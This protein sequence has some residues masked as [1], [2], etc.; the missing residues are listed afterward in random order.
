MNNMTSRTGNFQLD[1]IARALG[2]SKTTV[3][4]AI[5]GKGRVSPETRDKVL[6]CIR[7]MN[8]TPDT[9]DK[10]VSGSRTCNIG[11]VIPMDDM[12][13]EAPF[14]QTCLMGISKCCALRNHDTL[15]IGTERGDASQLKRVLKEHKADGIVITRPLQDGS[16][17]QLI[18]QYNIPYVTVGQSSDTNAVT[19]D[20]EHRDGCCQL[21]SYLM[22]NN[23]PNKL[24]LIIGSMEQTVN[25]S[26]YDGFVKAVESAG[27]PVPARTV[28][29]GV[30]SELQLRRV[31]D[32]LLQS[33][34]SC[35]I[36]GDDM[37][38][39]HVIN[40]LASVGKSIP[41][42]I[43]VA[44]FYN[45]MYLDMNSPPIT[46]LRFRASDLGAAA[47]TLLLDM[48]EGKD[49]P[50]EMLLGFEMLIRRSTM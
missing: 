2:I 44:S 29:L 19:I 34:C 42:D 22:M 12:E 8:Y 5:S 50:H 46:A 15:V 37:I 28:F 47:A 10:S 24:G 31:V 17:E 38:C 32:D 48:L 21:T 1:D 23:R 41:Q 7:V 14:F 30:N 25:K 33:G 11:V 20:S 18:A 45:S 13:T 9:A 43:R 3:S 4:R 36:C 39:M 26:R 35:M 40:I 6:E 16:M 49:I 27:A